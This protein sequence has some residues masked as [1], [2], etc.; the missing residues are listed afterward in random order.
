[1][2]SWSE[3]KW[4]AFETRPQREALAIHSAPDDRLERFFIQCKL[5]PT[6]PATQPHGVKPLFPGYLFERLSPTLDRDRVGHARGAMRVVNARAV[7]LPVEHEC[8]RELSDS[9]DAD[10][11]LV[12][13]PR[14]FDPGEWV[15]KTY[16]Q[17]LL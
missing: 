15:S 4:F 17:H 2:D 14:V 6:E 16:T 11:C 12:L 9:L 5:H 13:E 10:G 8:T 3:T 1:M 7:P